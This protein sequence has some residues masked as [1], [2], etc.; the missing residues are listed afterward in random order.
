M[1][2]VMRSAFARRCL[3]IASV[4]LAAVGGAAAAQSPGA[5]SPEP[6]PGAS[7]PGGVAHPTGSTDIVLRMDTSGGLAPLTE[8][9]AHAPE[10]TLYGDG[11][12]IFRG[13]DDPDGDGFPPFVQA[14]M[15]PGSMDALLLE[16]LD[17]GGLRDAREP[18]DGRATDLPTTVFTVDA[19]G[20]ARSV[21]VSG[22]GMTPPDGPDDAEYAALVDLGVKLVTFGEQVDTYQ[23]AQPYQPTTYRAFL[24]PTSDPSAEAIPW[25]WSDLTPADFG[26]YLDLD[27]VLIGGLKP[28]QAGRVTTVPSGGVPSVVVEDAAGTQYALTIRPLLPGESVDPAVASSG[29]PAASPGA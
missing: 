1:L 10:F 15:E 26:P 5:Q 4:A 18:F 9:L 24:L 12:V 8:V 22:L 28:E 23:T 29:A 27:G 25:P 11:T 2:A 20:V 19:D 3:L 16:A 17:Q 21:A 14:H 6:R 7:S 13:A